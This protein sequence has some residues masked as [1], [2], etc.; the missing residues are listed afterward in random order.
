MSKKKS[1]EKTDS[2]VL[3]DLGAVKKAQR[4][5]EKYHGA[6]PGEYFEPFIKKPNTDKKS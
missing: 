2:I 5:F 3:P 1:K 4:E 6:K